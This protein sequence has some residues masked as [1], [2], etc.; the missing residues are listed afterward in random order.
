MKQETKDIIEVG[1]V[2]CLIGLGILY[3]FI[4]SVVKVIAAAWRA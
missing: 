1:G 2:G 3:A 4:Y